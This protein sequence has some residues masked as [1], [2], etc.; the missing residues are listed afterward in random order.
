MMFSST[1]ELQMKA[2]LKVLSLAAVLAASA[3]AAMATPVSLIAGNSAVAAGTT[4]LAKATSGTE[5]ATTGPLP[6]PFI[7]LTF[8]GSFVETVYA[9]GSGNPLADCTPGAGCLDYVFTF[10]NNSASHDAILVA[11]MANYLGYNVD[12]AYVSLSGAAPTTVS[13][14]DFGTVN[15]NF[16]GIK[17]GKTSDTLVLFTDATINSGGL[18]G[19]ADGSNVTVA[20]LGPNQ[21]GSSNDSQVPEPS[22]LFLL[23]TGLMATVGVARRKF[24]A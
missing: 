8:N 14:D 12:A 2:T 9:N 21:T 23:G 20:D 5:V 15:W 7:A 22:S 18:F 24:K 13:L 19:A 4:S 6:D 10:K 3:T 1:Q 11:T 17:P 16:P